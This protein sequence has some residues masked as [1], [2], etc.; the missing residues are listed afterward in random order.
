MW[1]HMLPHHHSKNDYTT[2]LIVTLWYNAVIF[3]RHVTCL[4]HL[5]NL[6]T[7]V[8]CSEEPTTCSFCLCSLLHTPLLSF[9]VGRNNLIILFC[10]C[11]C[12]FLIV[13]D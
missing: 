1:Q 3:S 5:L 11:P 7:I 8:V 4:V 10:L 13:E 2:Q 6:G 12:S 9:L